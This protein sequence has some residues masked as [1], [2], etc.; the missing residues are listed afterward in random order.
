MESWAAAIIFIAIAV[1]LFVLLV[2]RT[3][4][5]ANRY[6]DCCG[7]CRRSDGGD[8]RPKTRTH[9]IATELQIINENQKAAAEQETNGQT[10]VRSNSQ[11]VDP[12]N[13][14]SLELPVHG[15]HYPD[16]GEEIGDE[17]P[18]P[19]GHDTNFFVANAGYDEPDKGRPQNGSQRQ[20]VRDQDSIEH[21]E[22]SVRNDQLSESA[23]E[24]NRA[25][26]PIQDT[27]DMKSNVSVS[28]RETALPESQSIKNTAITDTAIPGSND[29]EL[30]TPTKEAGEYQDLI[31]EDVAPAND[32]QAVAPTDVDSAHEYHS[33]AGN[34]VDPQR[35]YE[36]L[37]PNDS[38]GGKSGLE[39][40]VLMV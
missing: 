23:F 7:S 9:S 2:A 11:T 26:T 40:P 25:D 13:P 5:R 39:N 34:D 6:H 1:I 17:D 3:I 16:P 35:Y 18:P 8:D 14:D 28:D 29:E 33:A 27:G 22:H 38:S 21:T 20:D 10:L 12:L 32:Y 31:K 4:Y 37:I 24:K 30:A 19:G 36:A 15:I